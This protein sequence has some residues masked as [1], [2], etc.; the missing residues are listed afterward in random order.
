MG[1]QRQQG[2]WRVF[3]KRYTPEDKPVH[4]MAFALKHE[5]ID[6]LVSETM[7]YITDSLWLGEMNHIGRFPK[8]EADVEPL[9]LLFSEYPG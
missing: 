1:S 9:Y 2:I 6:L 4:H 7:P 8:I 3:D 5:N